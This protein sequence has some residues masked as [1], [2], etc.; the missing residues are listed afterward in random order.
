[1]ADALREE[2]GGLH[3]TKHVLN[4]PQKSEKVTEMPENFKQPT[5]EELKTAAGSYHALGLSVIPFKLTKKGEEYDKIILTPGWKKW[6]TQLQ[7]D[8]EFNALN[9]NEVNAFAVLLGTQARNGLYLSVVDYD[10]KG[11]D[12]TDEVK[13]KGR[14]LIKEFPITCM[15]QTVNKGIHLIYWTKTKPKTVG[16]YHNT[17]SL[18]LLGDKKLCL[19]APSLGYSKLNDNNPTEI[20]DIEQTFLSVM[21]KHGLLKEQ[22]QPQKTENRK[23]TFSKPRPCILEALK[24]QLT[25]PNGHLM[26]LAIAAEYK[27]LSYTDQE[28]IDL[29]KNQADFEV[30]TCS[31]Q[32]ASIDAEKTAKCETI[33]EYGYCL[34]HCT[35]RSKLG[36]KAISRN[37][38]KDGVE[39]GKKDVYVQRPTVITPDFIA[40]EIWNRKEPPQ[41]LVYFFKKDT[42]KTQKEIPSGETNA[43]DQNIIYIPVFND[44]V[45]KGLVIVPTDYNET[46]FKQLFEEID[47]FALLSYDPCGQDA[48]VR[49]LTRICVGSWFLDRFVAD[50]TYDIAGSGKFAPI[51]PIRGPSQS[52]KNRL[53]FVL[54]LLSY[55][56]YFEMSTY[57]IP[58]LYRPMDLWQGTLVLDEADFAN[59]NEKSELVHFLNCRATG[60]P[61]SRQNPKNP[62]VT[63]AFSNFGLT[64]V[65]QR[66]PFDDNATESRALPFYS[67]T[68]DKKLPVIETDEM[69][70]QGLELQNKLLYLRMKYYQQISINK[71]AW[72][73]G[74]KDHRLV[75]SLLPLIALS[76]HEP[77][78]KDT[79]TKTAKEVE[80]A[81]IEEKANSMD[82]LLINVLWEKIS[83]GLFDKWRPNI[84]YILDRRDIETVDQRE[85]EH[86]TALTTKDLADQF[87]WSPQ[88]IRKAIG[89]LGIAEKGLPTQVKVE[90]HNSRVIFFDPRRIEKRLREFVVNYAPGKVTE[91]TGVTD[92]ACDVP[93]SPLFTCEKQDA[94]HRKNVTDVTNVTAPEP[95]L[96]DF[97]E[98]CERPNKGAP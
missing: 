85:T 29:F 20:A 27:R 56:P 92:L 89:S 33:K 67:Q 71:E 94:L 34:P 68:S 58:S 45:K 80:K 42:F 84:F 82:G 11:N 97:D 73:N 98:T 74:L 96:A 18:E 21:K 44:S 31:A 37:G 16:T 43:K 86:K 63:D 2:Y 13:D 54:R 64:I 70:K 78:L 59:T 46:T 61:L 23:Q 93:D 14:M 3:E 77:S 7:T 32:V 79:I 39:A 35:L 69:L 28:I 60:T 15:E 30:N 1:M 38:C 91:V 52:G 83:E 24:L 25:G 17:A 5:E 75:A 95:F 40:E 47:K 57:R 48:L 88:S 50:P 10:C 8:K 51:I 19:M 81:K 36:A 4:F 65:T 12:V 6:E 90:G 26:R 66:R 53:A 76:K 49:L 9:W 62:K 41:Y 55:R 22:T 87:K 72:V